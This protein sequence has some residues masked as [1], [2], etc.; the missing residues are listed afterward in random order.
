MSY[1]PPDDEDF[2]DYRPNFTTDKLPGEKNVTGEQARAQILGY[3]AEGK[4]L[5][6]EL[7]P[8]LKAFME[9]DSG[10][11]LPKRATLKKLKAA[12]E[13]RCSGAAK[14]DGAA[15]RMV[16]RTPSWYSS[17]KIKHPNVIQDFEREYYRDIEDSAERAKWAAKQKTIVAV[18]EMAEAAN[19]R[20]KTTL[21]SDEVA[22]AVHVSAV[23][24]VHD[25]LGV[26][27]KRGDSHRQ[28]QAWK[29]SEAERAILERFAP[30][31]VDALDAEVVEDGRENLHE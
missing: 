28:A 23:K 13:F 31:E 4:S 11:L 26:V 25:V 16:G 27:G 18:A 14:S 12:V 7:R 21:E 8:A 9:K 20:L 5:P 30:R 1:L 2:L 22:P 15:A 17:L 6:S 19:A 3:W 29:P 10:Y 24:Q